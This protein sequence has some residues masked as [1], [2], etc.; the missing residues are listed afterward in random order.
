VERL[1]ERLKRDGGDLEG[2]QRLV[3]AYMVLGEAERAKAA[4]ADAR[5]AAAGDPEKLRRLDQLTKSLGLDG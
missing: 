2:W 4:A 3:R 1:A 5:R